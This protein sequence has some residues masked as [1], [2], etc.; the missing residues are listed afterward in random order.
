MYIS[1]AEVETWYVTTLDGLY[2]LE[3]AL[4]S[5]V[6]KLVKLSDA[7]IEQIRGMPEAVWKKFLEGRESEHE[8]FGSLAAL[9]AFEGTIRRDAA[10]R[11]AKRQHAAKYFNTFS[12]ITGE[13]H[14][15]IVEIIAL[16]EKEFQGQPLKRELSV[17]RSLFSDRNKIAHGRAYRGQFAFEPIFRKLD[18]AWGVWRSAVP[19][20]GEYEADE[21]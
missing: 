11:G 18:K 2:Y 15:K 7:T 1:L 4:H 16:W 5:D 19:D 9:A 6:K 17:L 8:M 12:A 3:K 14:P 10:W 13:K 20:F 21:S